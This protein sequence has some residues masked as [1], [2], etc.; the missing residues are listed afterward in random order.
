MRLVSDKPF[1]RE[2][3]EPKK[4]NEYGPRAKCL[5][6]LVQISESARTITCSD[7]GELVDPIW[8]VQELFKWIAKKNYEYEF[9]KNW[10][11]SQA[12]KEK[13]RAE[14]RRHRCRRCR[15]LFKQEADKDNGVS[16]SHWGICNPC[17]EKNPAHQL[18]LAPAEAAR[19]IVVNGSSQRPSDRRPA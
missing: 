19:P 2:S 4:V 7:C 5:H 8:L 18:T 3:A 17:W 15:K 11:K 10:N 12:D 16:Y 9:I 14:N 13:A 1:V 6:R